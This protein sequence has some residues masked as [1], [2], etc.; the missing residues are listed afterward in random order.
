MIHPGFTT[1]IFNLPLTAHIDFKGGEQNRKTHQSE[2]EN[3]GLK[4]G[5]L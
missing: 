4:E 1:K 5:A 2:F 3:H